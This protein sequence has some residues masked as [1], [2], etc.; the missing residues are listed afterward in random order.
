MQTENANADNTELKILSV[1]C[2]QD[3]YSAQPQISMS[4]NSFQ[5]L[6]SIAEDY[7]YFVYY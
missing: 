2:R 1:A 4:N 6:C 7:K 3:V 5:I